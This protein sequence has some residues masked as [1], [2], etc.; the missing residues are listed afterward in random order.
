MLETL[1][2]PT[3]AIMNGTTLGA[4]FE[5]ALSCDFRVIDQEHGKQVGQP[6]VKIG[7]LPGELIN[8]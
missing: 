7:V 3:L 1:P 8:Q 5:L 2:I 6:E 4:G